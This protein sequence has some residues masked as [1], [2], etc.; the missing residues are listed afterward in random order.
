MDITPL[1]KACIKTVKLQNKSLPV[2]DKNRIL[3][4]TQ[5]DDLSKKTK[6][7]KFQITQLK[8]FLVEN[9]AA[10]I[11]F[12]C[13]LKRSA[14]MTNEERD[15]IDR[16]AEKIITICTQFICELKLDYG[17]K[18]M[19]KQ[20]KQHVEAVFEL[21]ANYLKA[22]YCI[23]NDQKNYRIRRDLET[24]KFLKLDSERRRDELDMSKVEY[25]EDMLS[26]KEDEPLIPKD[27]EEEVK[28]VKRKPESSPRKAIESEMTTSIQSIEDDANTSNQQQND[29]TFG[30]SAEDLQMLEIEN[31]QLISEFKGLTEEVQQIERHV[32]DI[33]KL[34]ELFTEKVVSQA[35]DIDRIS[36]TVVGATENVREANE[37][38]REAIQ[39][40]AGLRVYVLFFLL[41]MSF[42]L[43]FLDWYND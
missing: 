25:K 6:E 15:L 17:A 9:R 7:I 33:A 27:D 19:T 13:H 41:V 21:L 20:Q 39:R 30:L 18:Q 22:V 3:K 1:F 4:T 28:A 10:Y 26:D 11:Q 40:N 14:Q 35:T 24:Y 23:F 2:P 31:K 32:H 38:I 42:S 5:K 43:L 12:A 34:Q 37:Q 8:N 36:N 16:E 29:E